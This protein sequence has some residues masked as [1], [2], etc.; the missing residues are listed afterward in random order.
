M[1][2]GVY[3]SPLSGLC[4]LWASGWSWRGCQE[5]GRVAPATACSDCSGM[6][7]VNLLNHSSLSFSSL[8]W[9]VRLCLRALPTWIWVALDLEGEGPQKGE[10]EGRPEPTNGISRREVCLPL[11]KSDNSVSQNDLWQYLWVGVCLR[12]QR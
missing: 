4:K 6:R 12:L 2:W 3:G 11:G 7:Q 10:K 5:P 9:K 1:E 8:W